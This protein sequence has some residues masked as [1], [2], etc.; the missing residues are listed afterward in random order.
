MRPGRV[1]R[2][3]TKLAVGNDNWVTLV[4]RFYLRREFM[5]GVMREQKNDQ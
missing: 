1:P 2:T 4:L 5:N 3:P